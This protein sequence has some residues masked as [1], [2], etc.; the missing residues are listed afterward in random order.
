MPAKFI[1]D[2]PLSIVLHKGRVLYDMGDGRFY[3]RKK[4]KLRP[5]GQRFYWRQVECCQCG[6]RTLL[7]V[8]QI[9]R[10]AGKSTC[11]KKCW[12]AS[13]SGEKHHAWKAKT[14][15]VRANGKTALLVWAPNHPNAR[16]GRV[17]EHRYVMEKKLGRFLSGNEVVHHI[18]CD[19]HN[20][21]PE[22]LCLCVDGREHLLAHGT[23]SLCVK[24][25]LRRGILAFDE[26]NKSYV[27]V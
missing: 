18:D 24:E 11:S 26:K 27:L 1:S 5:K 17:Y 15:K 8:S 20:N 13:R 19:P 10:S 12:A 14:E 9:A 3:E 6:T 22:N 25:L 21:S 2:N 16:H 7:P 23:L 4:T